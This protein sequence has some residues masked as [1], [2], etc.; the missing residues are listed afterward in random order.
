MNYFLVA[1]SLATCFAFA[2]EVEAQ[3]P[4]DSPVIRE[5]REAQ[6]QANKKFNEL[7]DR[8]KLLERQIIAIQNFHDAAENSKEKANLANDAAQR[9][10][11]SVIKTDDANDPYRYRNGY[12]GWRTD[13]S[14]R[15]GSGAA[16]INNSDERAKAAGEVATAEKAMNQN[17]DKLTNLKRELEAL[18]PDY[19]AADADKKAADEA[20]TMVAPPVVKAKGTAYELVLKNGEIVNAVTLIESAEAYT[21]KTEDKKFR[22]IP[23]SDVESYHFE[24]AAK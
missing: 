22:T 1:I 11:N 4:P 17:K 14:L 18:M 10:Q 19:T 3:K 2:D 5:A 8:K 7:S 16:V 21:V 6:I 15:N 12:A 20:M 24:H 9:K 23:K 13:E